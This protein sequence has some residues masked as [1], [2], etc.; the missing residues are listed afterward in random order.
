M[1]LLKDLG[2]KSV[3]FINF[4]NNILILSLSALNIYQKECFNNLLKTINFKS[5]LPIKDEKFKHSIFYKESLRERKG[6][7]F[8]PLS[9]LT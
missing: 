5:A 4:I 1:N 7:Y 2:C 9:F 6:I 3:I 8:S